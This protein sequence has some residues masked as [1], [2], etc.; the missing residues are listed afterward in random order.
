MLS[1]VRMLSFG[2]LSAMIAVGLAATRVL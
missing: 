1:A 2:S